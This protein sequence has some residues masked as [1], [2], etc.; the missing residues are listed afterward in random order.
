MLQQKSKKILIYFFLFLIIGS[1]NNKNFNSFNFPKIKKIEINGLDI[2]NEFNLILKLK[3]VKLDNLLFVDEKKIIEVINTNKLVEKYSVFKKYPS[4][5]KI[6]IIKTEFL[7]NVKKDNVNFFLGSNG[8][9]IKTNYVDKDLPF[10]FGKFDNNDFFILKKIIGESNFKFSEIRN[11]FYYKSG[12]WDIITHSEVKIKLPKNDIKSSLDLLD[13]I[14]DKFNS[15]KIISID[16]R[17]K[18]QIVIDEQ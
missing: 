14:L 5:L 17:Q 15:K 11:L 18:N 12:R 9:L 6:D 16:L 4:S 3:D 7:A 10:I 1:L 8:K 2:D 13:D